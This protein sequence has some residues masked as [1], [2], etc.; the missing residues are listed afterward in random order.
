MAATHTVQELAVLVSDFVVKQRGAW[1]HEQWEALC[2]KAA[3]LGVELDDALQEQLGMLLENMRVFYY[4]MPAIPRSRAKAKAK[5]KA[6]PKP[7]AKAKAKAKPAELVKP[8]ATPPA[9]TR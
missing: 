9:S 3:G 8:P 2:G 7:K 6:K 5:P 1:D 4:C